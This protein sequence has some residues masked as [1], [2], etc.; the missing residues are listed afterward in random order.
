MHVHQLVCIS[1]MLSMM[2]KLFRCYDVY[3]VY[4]ID[5]VDVNYVIDVTY[6]FI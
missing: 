4:M 6:M 3:D 1:R 2:F 5:V